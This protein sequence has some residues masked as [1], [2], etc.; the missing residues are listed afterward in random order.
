MFLLTLIKTQSALNNGAHINGLH[1]INN[2]RQFVLMSLHWGRDIYNILI[3]CPVMQGWVCDVTVR[4]HSALVQGGLGDQLKGDV[5]ITHSWQPVSENCLSS[6][7]ICT[8]KKM[9]F[10]PPHLSS[11]IVDYNAPAQNKPL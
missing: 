11:L 6:V 4:N 8:I 10:F 1:L 3:T 7:E 5:T 2:L 9:D